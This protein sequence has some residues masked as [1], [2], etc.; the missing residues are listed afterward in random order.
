[1]MYA[2]WL[3]EQGDPRAEYVRLKCGFD[4]PKAFREPD[5]REAL[6]S[7]LRE[8][9]ATV[10]LDWVAMIDAADK[11]TFLWPQRDVRNRVADESHPLLDFAPSWGNDQTNFWRMKIK[12]GDYLYPLCV[13]NK[14]AHVVARMRVVELIEGTPDDWIVSEAGGRPQLV[15]GRRGGAYGDRG[16]RVRLDNALPPA[17]LER[18][19]FRSQRSER[20]IKHVVDGELTSSISLQGVYRLTRASAFDLDCL[21]AG[22]DPG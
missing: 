12:P 5:E 2:D 21:I 3:E 10:S 16:T 20:K 11:Y 7:R 18:L 4:D 19:T 14:K 1:L 6:E 22:V 17:V 13:Q 15:A 8:I 9:E